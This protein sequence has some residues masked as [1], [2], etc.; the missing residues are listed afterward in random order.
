MQERKGAMPPSLR[1]GF[2]GNPEGQL[3]ATPG[4]LHFKRDGNGKKPHFI[5]S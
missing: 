1:L 5:I 2:D 3:Q 4:F